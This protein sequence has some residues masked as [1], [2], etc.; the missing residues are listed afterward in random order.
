MVQS[1]AI[2]SRR[3]KS[4]IIKQREDGTFEEVEVTVRY[5]GEGLSQVLSG[6]IKN[7]DTYV[8]GSSAVQAR[9]RDG[10]MQGPPMGGGPF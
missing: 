9:G 8:L 5:L 1:S 2:K 3:G 4:Y 6:G 7:G 10:I